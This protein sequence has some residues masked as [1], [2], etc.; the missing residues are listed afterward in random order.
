MSVDYYLKIAGVDGESKVEG[1]EGQ[2]QL[3]SFSWG[4]TQQG[5][6]SSGGGGGAGKVDMQDFSFST[7]I[8]KATAKLFA[9][10]TTGEHIGEAILTARK[11]GKEQ[12]DFLKVTFSDLLVSSYQTGGSTGDAIPV[13]SFSLN[14]TKVKFEYFVQDEKGNVT[15]AGKFEYDLKKLKGS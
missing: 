9:Y 15:P 6:F 4:A 1:K 10:C 8:S 11:A 12:K 5:S 14:F 2:I 13:E 7:S 3:S